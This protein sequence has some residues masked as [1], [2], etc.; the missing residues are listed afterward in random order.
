[1][2]RGHR[3]KAGRG[4]VAAVFFD[5]AIS[6]GTAGGAICG[7]PGNLPRIRPRLRRQSQ[8]LSMK[9]HI[10]LVDDDA[11]IRELLGVI[12]RGNYQL[13]EAESGAALK[14]A[15]SRPQPD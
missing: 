5:G 1:N 7:T 14:Q 11:T 10:L 3:V 2:N 13:S 6:S 12:L 15:F 8:K 4:R 9:A